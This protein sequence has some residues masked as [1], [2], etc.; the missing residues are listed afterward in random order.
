MSDPEHYRA[1]INTIGYHQ[2]E[3]LSTYTNVIERFA[4]DTQRLCILIRDILLEVEVLAAREQALDVPLGYEAVSAA[5]ADHFAYAI[6]SMLA[7][8]H[9]M[10][11][12]NPQLTGL[13]GGLMRT[14]AERAQVAAALLEA[15]SKERADG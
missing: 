15:Q 10:W 11:T 7:F 3:L 2:A 9:G 13:S 4:Q 6:L 14:S 5:N 12:K 8:E 1:A